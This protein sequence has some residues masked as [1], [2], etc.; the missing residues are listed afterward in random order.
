M[1][2]GALIHELQKAAKAHRWYQTGHASLIEEAARRMS[3]LDTAYRDLENRWQEACDR[4]A[5]LEA[6]D[7]SCPHCTLIGGHWDT[8]PDRK[9]LCG[10]EAATGPCL[11]PLGHNRGRLDYPGNHSAQHWEVFRT[12]QGTWGAVETTKNIAGEAM[13]FFTWKEAYRYAMRG[14]KP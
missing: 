2:T 14:G 8:C 3:S 7:R 11:M 12:S 4:I 6:P 10:A 5:Y 13:T 9:H 1:K